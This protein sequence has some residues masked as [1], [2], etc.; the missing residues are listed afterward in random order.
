MDTKNTITFKIGEE[1]RPVLET[2]N[3]NNSIFTELYQKAFVEINNYVE[4]VQS[5]EDPYTYEGINNIFAFIGERGAGKTSCMMSVAKAL[6][7]NNKVTYES[8]GLTDSPKNKVSLLQKNTFTNSVLIDP[9]FFDQKN[10]ILSLI[11]AHLFKKFR[12][13]ASKSS[14]KNDIELKREVIECFEKVQKNLKHFLSDDKSGNSDSLDTLVNFAATVDLQKDIKQL[15]EKYLKFISSNTENDSANFL[16]LMIDDIDLHTKHAREMVEQ[17]RK[18]FIQPNII[19]LIAVKIDQLSNV[20]KNELSQEYKL[21]IDKNEMS[22]DLINEMVERYLAKLFPQAQRL[23]LSNASVY[24]K[25]LLKLAEETNIQL[26]NKTVRE[27]ILDL[28]FQ[29][30]G[31]GFL[32]YSDV[33][34]YIIPTNLRD[35]RHLT[36]LLI[37]MQDDKLVNKRIFINYFTQE[38]VKNNIN[39]NGI[40]IICSIIEM[41]DYSIINKRIIDYLK[42]QFSN[43]K[44]EN[45]GDDIPDSDEEV[46]SRAYVDS[47]IKAEALNI[48]NESN[49]PYNISLGD[50]LA[51]IDFYISKSI[52]E[53]ERKL[54]F[55]LKFTLSIKLHEAIYLDQ[56]KSN[57]TEN[58]IIKADNLSGYSNFS[59]ILCSNYINV[60]VFNYLRKP[61]ERQNVPI[62]PNLLTLEAFSENPNKNMFGLNY[63]DDLKKVAE[64]LALTIA[65]TYDSE[66]TNNA[67]NKAKIIYGKK[68][69]SKIA[70]VAFNPLSLLVNTYD[71]KATYNR[72]KNGDK[73]FEW[74]V[75]NNNSLLSQIIFKSMQLDNPNLKM[76]DFS[77]SEDL[78]NTHKLK[79]SQRLTIKDIEILDLL[80]VYLLENKH[81]YRG[82]TDLSYYANF[83]DTLFKFK[84]PFPDS[85]D[86]TILNPIYSFLKN[87]QKELK[88]DDLKNNLPNG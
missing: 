85:I 41:Q 72:L 44:I 22:F 75:K 71:I 48:N 88:F 43:I 35:L 24:S 29:K 3:L 46:I 84:A 28:I 68:L 51:I 26:C 4:K 54:L 32:N 62:Y 70:K 11:I 23:Y 47:N 40:D 5:I 80:K 57:N 65:S 2:K 27:T 50:C 63:I 20:I 55:A 73:L 67:R 52:I 58:L 42:Y 25:K 76:E 66:N 38:F 37:S 9:S 34:N 19:V 7:N 12:D 77:M 16:V 36:S 18:Y 31:F 45:N 60:N 86:M 82:D 21:L 17:I 10:N 64:F 14:C 8:L 61:S 81:N 69:T 59:K 49:F 1:T 53:K 83:F 15:V 56:L 33:T 79:L 87:I 6:E 13:A 30:T 78:Y 39:S 74:A